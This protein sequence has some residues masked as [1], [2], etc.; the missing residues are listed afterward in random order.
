MTINEK[1]ELAVWMCTHNSFLA[2]TGSMMVYLKYGNILG[3]EPNDID[4]IVNMEEYEEEYELIL[5]PF[6]DKSEEDYSQFSGYSVLKRFW[7][8]GTKIEFIESDHFRY[9][10]DYI[11]PSRFGK[12]VDKKKEFEIEYN[13]VRNH[14]FNI[15]YALLSDLIDA[16]KLY[17]EKDDNKEYLDKTYKDLQILEPLLDEID[18]YTREY[19]GLRK[20]TEDY[21]VTNLYSDYYQIIKGYI[22]EFWYGKTDDRTRKY[23][24]NKIYNTLVKDNPDKQEWF[25]F[26][27]KID[28]HTKSNVF[29]KITNDNTYYG[30]YLSYKMIKLLE[31]LIYG[32]TIPEE[33]KK[34][35]TI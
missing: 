20:Y 12:S 19:R 2:L 1:I 25:D 31:S 15:K 22:T 7:I 26:M 8:K 24:E 23:L 5:P 9:A 30:N 3:R 11:S 33:I 4:F 17:F 13:S 14:N 18:Q 6:I 10:E 32:H 28:H 21:K 27:Q 35:I 29:D 16:K 34:Q